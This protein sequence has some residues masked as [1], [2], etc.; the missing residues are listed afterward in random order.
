MQP[1]LRI[2][3]RLAQH[4]LELLLRGVVQRLLDQSLHRPRG[5]QL[6]GDQREIAR[7]E[8]YCRSCEAPRRRANV[9][10]HGPRRDDSMSTVKPEPPSTEPPQLWVPNE[11]TP[12]S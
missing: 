6:G 5:E 3:E 4:R 11:D 7:R 10:G 9:P 1:E 12:T 2:A 8:Q